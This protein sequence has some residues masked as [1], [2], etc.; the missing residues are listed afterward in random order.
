MKEIL[1]KLWNEYLWSECN[2]IDTAEE[3]E[4][5]KK[6]E[7]LHEKVNAMLDQDQQKAMED[8]INTLCAIDSLF[9]KKAFYRG[10]EFAVAFLLEIGL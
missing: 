10:C 4:L 9:H 6:A 7:L 3:R 5:I 2:E 1:E 8:Y